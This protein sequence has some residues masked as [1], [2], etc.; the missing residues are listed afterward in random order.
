MSVIAPAVTASSPL[1]RNMPE[2]VRM[3]LTSELP[4]SLTTPLR[5]RRAS[6]VLRMWSHSASVKKLWYKKI[7]AS[8]SRTFGH[9]TRHSR[10]SNEEVALK[11][12]L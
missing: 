2:E 1:S 10:R 9:H 11:Q 3:V 12:F 7:L 5:S 4:S 6:A 8:Q